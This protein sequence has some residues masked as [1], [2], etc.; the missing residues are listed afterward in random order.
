MAA[1]AGVAG[2]AGGGGVATASAAGGAAGDDARG[3]ADELYR[4]A[5]GWVWKAPPKIN[6]WHKR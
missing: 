1:A 4:E 3:P 5:R 2:G 6:K